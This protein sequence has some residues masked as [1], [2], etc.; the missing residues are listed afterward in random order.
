MTTLPSWP[1]TSNLSAG[2]ATTEI[3]VD[4]QTVWEPSRSA[5][6]LAPTGGI[7]EVTGFSKVSIFG[8]SGPI[9]VRLDNTQ[10]RALRAV[11]NALHLRPPSRVV[12]RMPFSTGSPSARG[13]GRHYHSR[14]TVGLVRPWSLSHNMDGTWRRSLT[15]DCSLLRAVVDV[16]P[17]HEAKGTRSSVG[18]RTYATC[19]KIRAG[20]P[21]LRRPNGVHADCRHDAVFGADLTPS[22][23]SAPS[24]LRRE[25]PLPR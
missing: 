7:V 19:F 10:T 24:A 21:T 11:L 15:P 8:S 23:R 16:L 18:C 4:S 12:M 1:T 13:R 2:R 17:P 5:G 22:R 14:P 9:T 3:R 20:P 6:E 25:P